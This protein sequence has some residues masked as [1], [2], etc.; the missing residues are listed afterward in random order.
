MFAGSRRP[1]GVLSHDSF[2]APLTRSAVERGAD[3]ALVRKNVTG[4]LSAIEPFG[5]RASVLRKRLALGLLLI[6][7]VATGVAFLSA[8]SRGVLFAPGPQHKPE[9]V[10]SSN[11]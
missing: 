7:V 10:V 9:Q 6:V 4:N 8:Q 11:N 1:H 3:R 5:F 2:L